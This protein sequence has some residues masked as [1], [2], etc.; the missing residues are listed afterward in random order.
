MTLPT[1][2]SNADNIR[3]L[4]IA[5][6]CLGAV[7]V[8]AVVVLSIFSHDLQPAILVLGF[9]GPS[10]A[11]LVAALKSFENGNDI[12]NL[13]VQVDG[14]LTQLLESTRVAAQMTERVDKA[15]ADLLGKSESP[16]E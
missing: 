4:T 8:T 13:S 2:T 10:I 5:V 12:K 16:Q 1:T 7:G 11:A 6:V 9:L 15:S 3:I 14:R